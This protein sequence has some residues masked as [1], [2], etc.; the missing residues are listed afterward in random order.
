MLDIEWIQHLNIQIIQLVQ[1]IFGIHLSYFCWV[2][3]RYED[4][5]SDKYIYPAFF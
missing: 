2:H 4:K 1:R 5:A 3:P